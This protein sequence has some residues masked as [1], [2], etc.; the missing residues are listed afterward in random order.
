MADV[1]VSD[2]LQ[3][4]SVEELAALIAGRNAPVELLG[5]GSKRGFGRPVEGAA[6]DLSRLSGISLYEPAELVLSAGAGTP[7]AEIEA[8]LGACGQML[9]FEPP[10]LGAVYGGPA[11]RGTLGGLLACNLSGPRRVKAGAARD[12][13]LG[14]TAVNG[15]GEIFKTGGRVMKNV[16]GYDLCKLL[17]G[18]FGTLAAIAAATIKLLPRP[19]ASRTVLLRGLD[20]ASA[21][22][23]MCKALGSAQEVTAAAHLPAD[24]VRHLPIA[25]A[26]GALTALRLEG[27]ASSLAGRRA[28]LLSELALAGE[29]PAEPESEALWRALRDVG[30]LGV[31]TGTLWRLSVPPTAGAV[32]MTA[33]APVLDGRGRH[34]Y[35]WGGGLIWLAL[36]E[37]RDVDQ[38]QRDAA[39]VRTALA[40]VGGH[41]TLI[42]AD[43][44]IRA[45]V[46]VFQP[47]DAA[48]RGLTQRVKRSFDPLG[49]LNPGRMYRGV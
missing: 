16:T 45:A 34:F 41:A 12:Y 44:G 20:D 25:G 4:G 48:L 27:L 32:V 40:A 10:D 35:D 24:V 15:S 49:R 42:R 7:L 26:Q 29:E 22:V 19:E 5:H 21:V 38:V 17:A 6:L 28:A 31:E 13:F 47:Q 9:A 14:A 33:L 11:G 3:P 30:P 8:A 23:A 43:A 1:L 36:A 46:E 39:A 37:A 2:R 18:S